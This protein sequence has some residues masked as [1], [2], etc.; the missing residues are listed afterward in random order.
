MVTPISWSVEIAEAIGGVILTSDHQGHTT[1]FVRAN[2]CV[3]SIA[4]EYLIEGTLPQEGAR[5]D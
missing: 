4:V 1:L 2:E 3:D 5:C